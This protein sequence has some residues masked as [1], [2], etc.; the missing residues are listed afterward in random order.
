MLGIAN[1][2]DELVLRAVTAARTGRGGEVGLIDRRED[3]TNHE[4]D[5]PYLQT[6]Y[7]VEASSSQ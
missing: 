2:D 7:D 6:L 1:S 3:N 5:E 4:L